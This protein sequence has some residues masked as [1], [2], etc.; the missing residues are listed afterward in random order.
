MPTG[1]SARCDGHQIGQGFFCSND[2]TNHICSI[3]VSGHKKNVLTSEVCG[4]ILA[5][6]I[7]ISFSYLRCHHA[8]SFRGAPV[9]FCLSLL[10][11]S[12]LSKLSAGLII[13]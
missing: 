13:L 1:K 7:L 8:K 10:S 9:N 5:R 11:T 2:A 3:D 6:E 12:V 4:N